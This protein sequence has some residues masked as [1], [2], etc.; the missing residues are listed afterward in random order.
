MQSSYDQADDPYR[1]QRVENLARTQPE[2]LPPMRDYSE[3][4]ASPYTHPC[5]SDYNPHPNIVVHRY[6]NWRRS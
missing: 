3:M 6:G 1:W 5:D 2:P 4:A